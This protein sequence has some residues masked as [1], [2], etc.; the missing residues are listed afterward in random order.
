MGIKTEVP[1]PRNVQFDKDSGVEARG[2]DKPL[3]RKMTP[4]R[5]SG[6]KR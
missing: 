5:K 6:K 2:A 1:T 3:Q 4:K